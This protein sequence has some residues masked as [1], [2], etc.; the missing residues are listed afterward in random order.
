MQCKYLLVFGTYVHVCAGICM[1][2]PVSVGMCRY[3][4]NVTRP[5]QKV[6]AVRA[7]VSVRI[8]KLSKRHANHSKTALPL[9]ELE[10]PSSG[11]QM[12]L[13]TTEPSGLTKIKK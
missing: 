11:A 10:H 8:T 3:L 1:Y 4:I 7:G 6:M 9:L 12:T 5:A 2:V 13:Y